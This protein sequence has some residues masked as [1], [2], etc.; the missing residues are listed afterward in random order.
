MH[1]LQ[2][3]CDIDSRARFGPRPREVSGYDGAKQDR[4]S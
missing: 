2:A 4:S 3:A 1:S